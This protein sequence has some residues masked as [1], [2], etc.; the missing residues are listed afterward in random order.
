MVLNEGKQHSYQHFYFFIY[1]RITWIKRE[2]KKLG[3]RKRNQLYSED[4]IRVMIE[5]SA[6]TSICCLSLVLSP[7][8]AFFK[9]GGVWG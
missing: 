4:N 3:L 1:Y 8:S 2:F 5:V 7:D 6:C 9:E